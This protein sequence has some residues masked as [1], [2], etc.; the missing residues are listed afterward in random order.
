MLGDTYT[1]RA[2]H[3]AVVDLL[4]VG[5]DQMVQMNESMAHHAGTT[6]VLAF[7]DGELDPDTGLLHLGDIAVCVDTA[8]EVASARKLRV[9]DEVTLYALHGMLHLLGMR[10]HTP[11]RRR[12]MI[13]AQA[14]AFR[15]HSL[16]YE[17]E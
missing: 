2:K 15:R 11:A 5:H 9:R 3:N 17:M 1:R 8:R 7:D 14:D 16:R 13:E 12:Q 4:V 10:D 6:D